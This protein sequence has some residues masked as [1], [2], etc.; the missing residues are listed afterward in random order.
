MW[1]TR[2]FCCWQLKVFAEGILDSSLYHCINLKILSYLHVLSNKVCID[3]AVNDAWTVVNTLTWIACIFRLRA[4]FTV[5][6]CVLTG[7]SVTFEDDFSTSL[8]W[9]IEPSTDSVF[10]FN[11][12]D[13]L[14]NDGKLLTSQHLTFDNKSLCS[15]FWTYISGN[16]KHREMLWFKGLPHI[17]YWTFLKFEVITFSP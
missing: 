1:T 17:M 2:A 3:E 6:M 7:A 8:W 15:R 12:T 5:L 14:V 11:N 10:W 4:D 16:M 9:V 13:D